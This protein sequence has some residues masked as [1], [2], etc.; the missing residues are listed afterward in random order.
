MT[1]RVAIVGAGP[2]GVSAALGC[3][4][5]GYAPIVLEAADEPGASLR[6]WGP[7][8]FFTPLGMNLP[9]EALALAPGAPDASS[10]LTGPQTAEILAA[11]AR[12]SALENRV[13]C[14]HRVLA[15]TRRGWPRDESAGHPVRAEQPFWV[16]VAG[17]GGEHTVEV[18]AVLDASGVYGQPIPLVAPGCAGLGGRPIRRL[19]EL[20][21]RVAELAA[22][23]VLLLGHGHSAANAVVLF[24]ELGEGSR[25]RE[26]VWATRSRN[27]R[28]VAM[29]PS[30]PLPERERVVGRANLLAQR[31]PPWLRVERAATI[32][33]VVARAGG[34]V[35]DLGKERRI[36][37]DEVVALVGYRPGHDISAELPVEI[38]A[39]TEGAGR[40]TRALC[41]VT[42]CLS[43]PRISAEDLASGEPRFH[44]VGSKSY[45]R[46]ST[47][48]LQTGRAQLETV[49]D[50]L[51]RD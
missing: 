36:E 19:G 40:L 21:A 39:S 24:D 8:R 1:R 31:P 20:H 2:I 43:V 6:A 41:D 12:S 17:T 13:R 45:G 4:R 46:A 10:L 26:V 14:N 15:I 47:F 25:P 48:L 49:L 42:D 33:G 29:V 27:L 32:E 44:L 38:A 5:R 9:E 23:R 11:I 16:V 28:P 50:G 30:D 7:T 34:L 18:D 35:V 22:R 51:F 37:V 3:L